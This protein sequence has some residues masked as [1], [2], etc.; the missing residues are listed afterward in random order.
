MNRTS[1]DD[2]AIFA[3]VARAR[4]F[5]RAAA[6]LGVS[7][8]ALS[9]AMRGLEQRLGLRLLART[10]RSVGLTEAGEQLLDRLQ[11]ALDG[12]ADGLDAVA[13][14]RDRPAG[15]VRITC[16][17]HAA[18][19]VLW[20]V[21]DRVMAE[22]PDI[23]VE[24][25]LDGA[26]TDIVRDRF[27]AGVRLGE[28]VER[29]MIALRI[30]PELEMAVVAAPNYLAAAGRPHHPRDLTRHRCI[31]LR[32]STRGDLYAWEFERGNQALNVRVDGGFVVNDTAMALRAALAGHGLAC[33]FQDIVQDAID[34]GRLVR[35]LE[36]WCPPFTGYHIYYPSR[37]QPS[38]AFAVVVEALVQRA[39]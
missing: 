27:D 10:T 13:R 9:H 20:P 39:R 35:V 15:T 5:T 12:I 28:Q 30:G 32:L 33:L 34:D 24:L 4:S 21:I 14:L 7:Q 29:D 38:P 2:L 11:P 31:N 36:D 26:L 16:G 23:H 17:R 18:E 22:H 6:E 37:R 1:L 8:S 19:T 3:A 25:S